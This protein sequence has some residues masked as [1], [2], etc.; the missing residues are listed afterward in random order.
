VQLAKNKKV[1]QEEQKGDARRT[2]I[3][4]RPGYIFYTARSLSISH[5]LVA[6]QSCVSHQSIICLLPI[7]RSPVFDRLS[8]SCQSVM[9]L[10]S[11]GHLSVADRSTVS[12][13]SC[14]LPILQHE[15]KM[16][17]PQPHNGV[18]KSRCDWSVG[19]VSASRG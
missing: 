5:A 16:H 11:V 12:C 9:C 3:P 8:V 1:T 19:F 2:S 7:G 10:L 17:H 13:Q 18:P 6:D 14:Q 15:Q 4:C